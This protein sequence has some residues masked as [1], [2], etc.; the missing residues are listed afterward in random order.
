M[1]SRL[2]CSYNT[3]QRI[4][5]CNYWYSEIRFM[6]L[7]YCHGAR[8]LAIR[9]ML[10][11][12]SLFRIL[13]HIPKCPDMRQW[14]WSALVQIWLAAYSAPNHYLNQWWVIV[15][16]ILRKKIIFIKIQN[17]SLTKMHF[18]M[19]FAKWRSLCPGEM[20]LFSIPEAFIVFTFMATAIISFSEQV[21]ISIQMLL[22]P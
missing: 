19:S 9:K 22:I 17:F 10:L 5:H 4:R 16:W 15:N 20:S 6:Y 2:Y 1:E 13:T 21:Y 11:F 7:A 18:K 12:A 8:R 3:T 14:I